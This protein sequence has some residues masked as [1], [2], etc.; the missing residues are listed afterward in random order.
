MSMFLY[1]CEKK[2]YLFQRLFAEMLQYF[3][4]ENVCAFLNGFKH[5]IP[6][7]RKTC[8]YCSY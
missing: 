6:Y 4:S 1:V 3:P 5:S 7:F 8:G 2:L